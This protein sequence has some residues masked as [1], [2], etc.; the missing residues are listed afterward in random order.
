MMTNVSCKARRG[1]Q[2]RYMTECHPD[3][4]KFRQLVDR[5]ARMYVSSQDLQ[6]IKDSELCTVGCLHSDLHSE[7]FTGSVLNCVQSPLHHGPVKLSDVWFTVA[8]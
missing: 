2:G 1:V 6:V 4:Y 7:L 5:F 8:P 3:Y